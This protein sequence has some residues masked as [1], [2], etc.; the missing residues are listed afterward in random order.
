MQLDLGQLREHYASLSD[1]AL[2]EIDPAD[3][4]D[5]ARQCYEEEVRRRRPPGA[6]SRSPRAASPDSAPGSAIAVQEPE[7]AWGEEAAEVFSSVVLPGSA[8]R[9]DAEHA[10]E[11]LRAAGI[12]A[13]VELVEIPEEESAP[14][15]ATHRWR[16]LVPG[17]L[18][19]R[20]SS[21]LERDIFN[22]EFEIEWRNHLAELSEE[23]LRAM[24]PREAFC[25]LFDRIE[26]I[27][28]AYEEELAR[29]RR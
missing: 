16:V 8:G 28:R 4:I 5:A 20:A 23:D 18:N 12:P 29:R 17:K 6:A 19:Q 14:S 21:V 3:L 15:R 2:L 10:G 9:E 26:R 22:A 24:N 27:T 1:E 13:D 7:P 25:G 11:V